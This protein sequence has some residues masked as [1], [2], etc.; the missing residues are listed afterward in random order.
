MIFVN[1]IYRHFDILMSDY[2]QV[3]KSCAFQ[4][5]AKLVLQLNNVRT[6]NPDT[7]ER[8]LSAFSVHEYHSDNPRHHSNICRELKMS[9]DDNMR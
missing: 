7:P 2:G 3:K 8:H 5:C 1:L 6:G 9:T 4:G